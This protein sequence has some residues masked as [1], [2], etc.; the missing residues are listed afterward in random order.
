MK[1]QP[2]GVAGELCIGGDGLARGYLNRP[3][4]TG[5][6]FVCNPFIAGGRM[7]RTGDLARWLPDG[8]IEYLGRID[9]QVKI[10]GFR[11]EL[12]EIENRL[13]KHEAI[14]EAVVIAKEDGNGAKYLCAY[15][16]AGRELTV[17]ELREYLGQELPEYMVPSYF[18][19]LDRLP[20]TP[21]GKIDRKA[22]PQPEGNIQTGVEYVAPS[23]AT[24]EKLAKI[25]REVLGL[26]KIGINDSFFDIG[27]NSLKIVKLKAEIDKICSNIITISDLFSFST[28]SKLAVHMNDKLNINYSD[29]NI[30]KS[31]VNKN[32]ELN[33]ILN[34]F[35]KGMISLEEA[36]SLFNEEE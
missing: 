8:N 22:L 26:E 16:V 18:V 25:W 21:N 10:R 13:V 35:E 27:G 30:E 32:K 20:L 15:L 23:N 33:D 31:K 14:K 29:N 28:I 24:E 5:D 17:K 3:E 36:V 34:E 6:R 19:Q 7:Y 4:L 2:I 11:I 12:G 9:H 1:L